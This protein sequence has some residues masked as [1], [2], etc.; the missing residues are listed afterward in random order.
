MS[1]SPDARMLMRDD[2]YCQVNIFYAH[3]NPSR[4]PFDQSYDSQE[5]VEKN[6]F[7]SQDYETIKTSNRGARDT[8][9]PSIKFVFLGQSLY[10]SI[11]FVFSALHR[12]YPI[13]RI[14]REWLH[15]TDKRLAHHFPGLI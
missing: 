4:I 10:A 11:K 6:V 12:S 1:T 15:G 2:L 13:L 14:S 7:T 5:Y 3:V 9:L 8:L